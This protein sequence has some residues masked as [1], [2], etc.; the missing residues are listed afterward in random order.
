VR[1]EK[2]ALDLQIKV[3]NTQIEQMLVA[4]TVPGEA[5]A[6]AAASII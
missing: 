5:I 4:E 3:A 6:H 2:R 1:F